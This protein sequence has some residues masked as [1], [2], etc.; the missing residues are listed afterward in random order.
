MIF[1]HVQS[2]YRVNISDWS[3]DES[4]TLYVH[5]VR[6]SFCYRKKNL[7]WKGPCIVKE[8]AFTWVPLY[9]FFIILSYLFL[10]FLIWCSEV[11][12][13]ILYQSG[14]WF[15]LL[16]CCGLGDYLTILLFPILGIPKMFPLLY[17]WAGKSCLAP[18]SLISLGW[19]KD[20]AAGSIYPLRKCCP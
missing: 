1:S 10:E 7:S 9:L 14:W 13:E 16:R 18:G 8:G 3:L 19:K 11:P 20:L 17:F 5:I 12:L 4:H 15:H 6:E 2:W